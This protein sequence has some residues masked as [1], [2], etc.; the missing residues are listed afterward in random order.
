M[1]IDTA[2]D[3][4]TSGQFGGKPRVWEWTLMVPQGPK[5]NFIGS[6]PSGVANHRKNSDRSEHRPE[7]SGVATFEWI[8]YGKCKEWKCM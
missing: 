6:H 3:Q 8:E 2:R 7:H 5:G 4:L 1:G